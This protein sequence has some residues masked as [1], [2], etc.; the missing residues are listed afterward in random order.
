ISFEY[1]LSQFIS[2]MLRER[3]FQSIMECHSSETMTLINSMDEGVMI[4]SKDHQ[5]FAANQH[6]SRI[7][8]LKEA[9]CSD[10]NAASYPHISDL[11]PSQI[12]TKLQ[13]QNFDGKI[14]PVTL[15]GQ[16]YLIN[17]N[18]IEVKGV[19]TGIILLFSNFGKMRESVFKAEKAKTMMTFDDILGECELIQSIKRQAIQIADCD[20]SVLLTG[21]T[22]TGKE[23]FSQAIHGASLRKND[24]FLPIN[25]G[26]IPENLIESELFGYEKGAFTGASPAG[27]QGKFE[28]CKNGTLFLDEIGDLPLPMQVKLLR[29]LESKEIIRI[30]GHTSIRANPRIISATS[31]HLENM[32]R[33]HTFREDLFY[34][35]N[36]TAIDIPPLRARG[37]DIIILARHFLHHFATTYGKSIEGF[38]GECEKLL[39]RY[40]FPG[41]I[42][43]L[44][45]LVECAVIFERNSLVGTDMIQSKMQAMDT[46]ARQSL[47]E[48]TQQYER[49]IVRQQVL[50]CGNTTE[51][52][53]IAAEQ[54]GISM[55]TLYRKL[56]ET[57]ASK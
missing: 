33:D 39:M 1:Q 21:E 7:L 10:L 57:H 54:L 4:L 23:V 12:H 3:E 15:C 42:R 38:T 37:Y 6:I 20:V 18:P 35:L 41:N 51:G 45:N 40:S 55:A 24:I 19:R 30:G 17:A 32:M 9:I 49:Q 56:G 36:I 8:D 43:E 53:K 50:D 52:K 48:L 46:P 22:G 31:L 2:T 14:G 26:A 47:A 27:R 29:A 28:I 34:R 25:C 16:E 44:R 13:Q 11:L 5:I